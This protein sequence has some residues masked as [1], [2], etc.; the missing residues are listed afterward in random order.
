[1]VIKQ[2]T[3]TLV[4][5]KIPLKSNIK[6]AKTFAAVETAAADAGQTEQPH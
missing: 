3:E 2:L 5:K 1:M 6:A 4:G